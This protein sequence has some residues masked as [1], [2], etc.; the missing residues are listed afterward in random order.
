MDKHQ[1]LYQKVIDFAKNHD[2][3]RTVIMNGSKVNPNIS[4]DDFQDYDIVFYVNDFIHFMK[5]KEFIKSFGDILVMQTKDVQRPDGTE[6]DLFWYIYLIQFKNGTRLDLSIL[7]V[8]DLDKKVYDDSL[9]KVVLDKDDLLHDIPQANE[10]SYFVQKPTKKEMLM[11]IN[12]FYWVCPYVGK[13][14]ARNHVFY[15]IKH[16]DILR[17]EIER[18]ID[19]WIGYQHDF[20][21][22][23][24]K[25]K[26]RYV[27]LLPIDLY[28]KYTETYTDA[29]VKNI[30]NALY[31]SL[32]LFDELYQKIA[33]E[34]NVDYHPEYKKDILKFI[35]YNYKKNERV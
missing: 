25:G 9:T 12:E 22:S 20:K 26:H 31:V 27:D 29:K 2:D 28:N 13:G 15:S 19:W 35:D 11:T 7:D 30:W 6:E 5:N 21:I 1:L 18:M 14:M 3:V 23:V 8:K 17:K 33:D 24:G 10:S 32:D 34:S 4:P 16:L